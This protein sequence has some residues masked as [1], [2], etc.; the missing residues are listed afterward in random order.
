MKIIFLCALSLE[1]KKKKDILTIQFKTSE[2]EDR[3]KKTILFNKFLINKLTLLFFY[4]LC[5]I[6]FYSTK[7]LMIESD[8]VVSDQENRVYKNRNKTGSNCFSFSD[9]LSNF[10]H[11]FFFI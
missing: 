11:L 10:H 1:G 5:I 3:K 8:T 6:F 9:S 7:I 4:S 2:V